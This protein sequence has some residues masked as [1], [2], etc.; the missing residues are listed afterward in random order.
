MPLSNPMDNR[1]H[2]VA[3]ATP[4]SMK[5]EKCISAIIRDIE[6]YIRVIR[7]MVVFHG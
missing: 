2:G 6:C 1:L 3:C 7:L 4:C 5:I